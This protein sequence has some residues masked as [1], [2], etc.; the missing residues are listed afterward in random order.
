MVARALGFATA[1]LGIAV[2]AGVLDTRAAYNTVAPDVPPVAPAVPD[3]IVRFSRTALAV[4]D[5]LTAAFTD[6][7]AH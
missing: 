4:P 2:G 7:R 6:A 5:A 3:L 1:A